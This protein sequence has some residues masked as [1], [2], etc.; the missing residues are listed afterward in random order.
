[1]AGGP[2]RGSGPVVAA[3]PTPTVVGA[4][5]QAPAREV[6]I[7][8]LCPASSGGRPGVRLI[9]ARKSLGWTDDPAELEELLR[10]GRVEGFTVLGS[11]GGR[12]GTFTAV[13]A[14]SDAVGPTAVG[15]YAGAGAC[16]GAPK[17]C[18][19][20]TDGCG[21]AVALITR[22]GEGEPP[23]VRAGGA[24]MKGGTLYADLD[25]DGTPVGFPGAAFLDETGAPAEEIIGTPAAAPCAPTFHAAGVVARAK[26]PKAFQ[27]AD[28]VAVADLD[29]DG[30]LE[31]V[32]VLRYGDRRTWAIFGAGQ[33]ERQL[34]QLA[35]GQ[36]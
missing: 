31:L 23:A 28:V 36:R 26:D 27:G 13:G 33:A 5:T 2:P 3:P 4:T 35:E 21:L 34:V 12:A 7:G 22:P 29:D 25:G 24:C 20:M 32:L 17:S 9:A 10:R 6:A 11:T 30:R 16:D 18:T 1:M 8:A 19:A 15:G 14:E